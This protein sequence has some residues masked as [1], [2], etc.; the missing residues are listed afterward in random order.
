MDS[1]FDELRTKRERDSVFDRSSNHRHAAIVERA[2]GIDSKL[3]R[4]PFRVFLAPMNQE[5]TSCLAAEKLLGI[6][7]PPRAQLIR[8]FAQTAYRERHTLELM[9]LGRDVKTWLDA[10]LDDLDPIHHELRNCLY[11]LALAVHSFN[12]NVH[13]GVEFNAERWAPAKARRSR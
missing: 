6:H 5:H 10:A 3:A 8:W 12:I 9:D 1:H 2:D 4:N 11:T 13:D 7:I